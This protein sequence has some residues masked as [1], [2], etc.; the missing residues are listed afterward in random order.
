MTDEDHLSLRPSWD[1]LACGRP[2]PC[3]N[4]KEVMLSEFRNF[5]TVLTI[6]MSAQMHDALDDLTANG[7]QVP[8]DLYDRF[9]TWISTLKIP[10]T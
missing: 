2:W 5:P 10:D 8:P 6:Y 1:C 7:R 4:A 3:A 9:L